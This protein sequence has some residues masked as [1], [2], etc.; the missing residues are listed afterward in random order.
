MSTITKQTLMALAALVLVTACKKGPLQPDE[1]E[2]SVPKPTSDNEP[3]GFTPV[4][5]RGFSQLDEDNW[6]WGGDRNASRIMEEA[7]AP[8]SKP[9]IIRV[10]VAAG[11]ESG[12]SPMHF[13]RNIRPSDHVYVNFWFRL[14]ANWKVNPIGDALIAFWAGDQPRLFFGWRPDESGQRML[15]TLMVTSQLV[16]GGSRWLDPNLVTDLNMS[17]GTWHHVELELESRAG[18]TGRLVC[19]F[20]GVK[21]TSYEDV[22]Y[23]VVEQSRHWAIMQVG[24]S[25]GGLTQPLDN[26]QTID[27]DH[28]YASAKP[29]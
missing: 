21:V 5:N 15:P 12:A 14:S 1:V 16:E 6:I 26:T 4:A 18:A 13:E 7:T 28:I 27:L 20:D 11:S 24:P 25:W 23:G 2:M 17:M 22:P 3:A 29:L 19:W 8:Q 10:T 9:S